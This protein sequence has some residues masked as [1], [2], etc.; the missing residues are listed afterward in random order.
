MMEYGARALSDAE[1]LAIV[2]RTGTSRM[3]I[4]E[5][6]RALLAR[7]G[8]SL[9]SLTRM[10]LETMCTTEGIG[11]SK[12]MQISAIAELARRMEEESVRQQCSI[13]NSPHDAYRNLV[14]LFTSDSVEE[15]WCLFLKR[16]RSVI[17]SMMVSRGGET[18]TQISVKSIVKRAL[19]CGAAAVILSH[20]HPSGEAD[21]STADIQLTEK[22]NNAMEAFDLCLMD[23]IV[24]ADSGYYSFSRE[25]EFSRSG[26][27]CKKM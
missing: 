11:S 17:G 19:E 8:G 7:A 9:H 5:I 16:N 21:P 15:C 6:S 24:I 14:P 10:S 18:M 25:S 22:L 20:N 1:L 13:I 23:H 2:L 3:N 26:K 4:L 27:K 12:A